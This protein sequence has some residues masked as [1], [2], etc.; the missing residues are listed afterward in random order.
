MS[1]NDSVTMQSEEMAIASIASVI[2]T[3]LAN[4]RQIQSCVLGD[5][6]ELIK[7]LYEKAMK[8]EDLDEVLQERA[9]IGSN[10]LNAMADVFASDFC[11]EK[12]K[13]VDYCMEKFALQRVEMEKE[14]S[15]TH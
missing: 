9:M 4:D 12:K 6:G 7:I 14:N 3:G 5:H 2:V 13:L 11:E 8:K 1:N 15:T 10:L